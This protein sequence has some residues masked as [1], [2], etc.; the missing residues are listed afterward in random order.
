MA[1][2]QARFVLMP[3]L[4]IGFGPWPD[5]NPDLKKYADVIRKT[6]ESRK[7]FIADVG[8]RI[9]WRRLHTRAALPPLTDNGMHLSEDGYRM[10]DEDFLGSLG[11]RPWDGGP[12]AL[13]RWRTLDTQQLRQTIIAK[14]ELYFHRWRPANITYLFLFRKHEQGQNAREIPQFDPLVEAKEKE[15]AKLRVTKKQVSEPVPAKK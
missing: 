12:D 11:I 5:R 8:E 13:M 10:T 4:P 2:T 9:D 1:P 14:N 6:G 3:P 15:I 7:H